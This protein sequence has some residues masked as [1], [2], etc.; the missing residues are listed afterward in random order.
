MNMTMLFAKFF[1]I[2][3]IIMALPQVFMVTEFRERINAMLSNPAHMMIAGVVSL[4]MGIFLVLLH[5]V[6]VMDW[7]VLVTFFCWLTLFKGIMI[8]YFPSRT[9]DFFRSMS[10]AKACL[11]R[12]IIML[13]LGGFLVYQGFF[14][15][16]V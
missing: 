11:I 16:V 5:N 10:T 6:W 14:T 1:G 15:A 3:L 7:T 2:F 13:V 9:M 8:I 12:G 4:M